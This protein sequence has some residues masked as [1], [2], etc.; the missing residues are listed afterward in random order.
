[1]PRMKLCLRPVPAPKHALRGQKSPTSGREPSPLCP[2]AWNSSSR[3]K[4]SPTCWHSS[5]P[6]N[7]DRGNPG[8]PGVSPA[9]S[10]E[11]FVTWPALPRLKERR[12]ISSTDFKAELFITQ[13][14]RYPALRGAFQIAFH[15]QIG[16]I[17]LLQ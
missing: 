15:D 4:N 6:P 7:G 9:S 16:L 11:C 1:M 13:F 5:N 3:S 14:R 10:S 8:S 17:H 2:P 12:L